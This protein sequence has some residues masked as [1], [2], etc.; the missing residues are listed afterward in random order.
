MSG[1]RNKNI[2]IN[3]EI[4]FIENKNYYKVSTYSDI[5]VLRNNVWNKL[6]HSKEIIINKATG[7]AAKITR[8]T[9]DKIIN[10]ISNFK[11]FNRQYIDDLNGA[12]YLKQL[13]EKEKRAQPQVKKLTSSSMVTLFSINNS[14][15]FNGNCQSPFLITIFFI[16]K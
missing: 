5:T 2:S 15:R 12:F 16:D 4:D 13:F 11:P 10:P 8:A 3:T 7:F 14:I 6:N 9:I 1:L